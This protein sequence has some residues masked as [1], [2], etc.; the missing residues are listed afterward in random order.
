MGEA[1]QDQRTVPPWWSETRR[2]DLQE[3]FADYLAKTTCP[4]T[5][6]VRTPC[7]LYEPFP[8]WFVRKVAGGYRIEQPGNGFHVTL[9]DEGPEDELSARL[10]KWAEE[11]T[12]LTVEITHE[13]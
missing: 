6:A 9:Q 3:Y 12:S 13:P 8:E 10:A 5:M 11:G 7:Q 4:V 2:E 1:E